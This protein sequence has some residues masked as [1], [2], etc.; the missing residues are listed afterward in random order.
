M[1]DHISLADQ[2]DTVNLLARGRT[3]SG[4]FVQPLAGAT[5]SARDSPVHWNGLRIQRV[6]AADEQTHSGC[7]DLLQWLFRGVDR[8]RV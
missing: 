1:A 4:A 8:N 3:H 6:L 5:C 7:L 2:H